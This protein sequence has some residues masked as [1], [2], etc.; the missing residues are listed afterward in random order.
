MSDDEIDRLARA[1]RNAHDG[2]SDAADQT[3]AALL[4][5]H[6]DRQ[7]RQRGWW[8]A[9]AGLALSL[10]SIP[11]AWALYTGWLGPTETEAPS[12]PTS[13]A[14]R[15]G[16]TS[17]ATPSAPPA[18]PSASIA[19]ASPSPTVEEPSVAPIA[20]R[21]ERP[22]AVERAPV[23]TEPEAA[24]SPDPEPVIDPAERR[25]YEEAHHL[26]FDEHDAAGA[27]TAWE[28]YL[29]SYPHGRFAPEARYNRATSLIRLG[30]RAEAVEALQPFADGTYGSYRRREAT[31]LLGAL[32]TP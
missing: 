16:R 2:R 3:R 17:T 20:A 5:V 22:R 26:H 13:A 32:G 15:G 10:L 12:T 8:L 24:P 30:R 9:A 4:A 6:R 7:Q 18:A 14:S 31:E 21:P 25:A 29:S 23:V 19:P 11:T 28:R 27:V 1:Y